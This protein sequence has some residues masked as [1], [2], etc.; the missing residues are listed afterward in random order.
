MC[1][2]YNRIHEEID[3]KGLSDSQFCTSLGFPAS[4]LSDLKTGKKKS[5]SLDKT[6]TIAKKLGLSL[7]YLVLG[8]EKAHP[9]EQDELAANVVNLLADMSPE[10]ALQVSAFVEGLKAARKP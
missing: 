9:I 6:V 2:L 8:E 1:N 10:E 7:D 5:L 4:M 3:R